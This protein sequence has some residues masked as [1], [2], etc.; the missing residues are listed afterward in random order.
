MRRPKFDIACVI[1]L[2]AVVAAVGCAPE[3]P[4]DAVAMKELDIEAEDEEGIEDSEAV[5]A[6]IDGEEITREEF[7]RRL[8]GLA[9]FAR[10]RV[11][12]AEDREG[13]LGRIAEFEL[14]ADVA[15]RAGD[16]ASAPVR[17]AMKE[18]MV[19]LMLGEYVDEQVSISDIDDDVRRAYFDANKEE[20]FR[21]ER[22]RLARIFF[23]K[24][25][26]AR[27]LMERWQEKASKFDDLH[28]N[29]RRFAYYYSEDRSTGDDSGVLGWYEPGDDH[30][31]SEAIFEW[32]PE[33]AVGPMEIDGGF[34]IE[35][36]I[37]VEPRERPEFEELEQEL[38]ERIF[39]E[40]RQ[41]A[42]RDFIEGLTAEADVEVWSQRVADLEDAAPSRGERP[43]RLRDIPLEP[44]GDGQ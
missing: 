24:E 13:F 11:Q 35:M 42:R 3:K 30:H 37:E 22:R 7:D 18:T 17:H 16:G 2:V 34:A 43:V 9:D 4:S 12:S 33:V 21:P 28:R 10:V 32:E 25:E 40:R 23:E 6:R 14:M 31:A 8:S 36:V 38:T 15:E 5:V 44:A 1:L 19:S 41:E 26:D 20:F 27:K 29:F 39:E